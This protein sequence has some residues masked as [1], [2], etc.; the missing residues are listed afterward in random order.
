MDNNQQFNQ[1][2]QQ[3]NPNQQAQPQGQQ[4]QQQFQ[5][6]FNQ[7]VQ[8][9]VPNMPVSQ[10]SIGLCIVLS[11]ITCGIYGLYWLY[12]LNEDAKVLSGDVN[13]TSGGVVILLGIVTCGIYTLYWMF[14]QG[15]R[16]DNAKTSRGLPSSNSGILYLILSLV[17]LAII[18]YALMQNEI[19]NMVKQ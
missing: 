4:Y 12:C 14:K 18:S 2:G 13:A 9:P 5:Q 8:P 6:Q 7:A 11:I 1:Q 3:P 15:E 17:G 16:I 19:N 10:R